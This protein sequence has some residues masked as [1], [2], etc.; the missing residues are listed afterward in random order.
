MAPGRVRADCSYFGV[1]RP[2]ND[3]ISYRR[4]HGVA[5]KARTPLWSW[6]ASLEMIFREHRE[7]VSQ[8]SIVCQTLG[9]S[10]S[11]G[12]KMADLLMAVSGTYRNAEGG[13]FKV[14]SSVLSLDNDYSSWRGV[15]PYDVA[16]A[17]D[18]QEPVLI[19]N[20]SHAMVMISGRYG[21]NHENRMAICSG[22]VADPFDPEIFRHLRDE[23]L[24]PIGAPMDAGRRGQ[25]RFI[26]TV[27]VD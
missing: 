18:V 9:C 4:F 7:R 27:N 14:T 5:A 25:L 26:C 13:R 15:T 17:L 16:R 11:G 22:V 24:V 6:A 2:R 3:G 8:N 10:P 12:L 1:S 20:A 21:A 23:E 19:C